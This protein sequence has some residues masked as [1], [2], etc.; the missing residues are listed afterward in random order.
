MIFNTVKDKIDSA[1]AQF[2]NIPSGAGPLRLKSF[3]NVPMA[4]LEMVFRR[5]KYAKFIDYLTKGITMI[6]V[7][8]SLIW[9]FITGEALSERAVKLLTVAGGKLSASWAN[10]QKSKANYAAQMSK[11]VIKKMD[12]SGFAVFFW[13]R[14]IWRN[15]RR[16]R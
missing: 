11:E 8:F 12:S 1:E 6:M 5:E 10:I 7:I 13:C 15:K 14:W 9:A 3:R 4:D 16:K 2:L